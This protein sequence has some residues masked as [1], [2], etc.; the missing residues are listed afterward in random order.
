[1]PKFFLRQST[2]YAF[3]WLLEPPRSTNAVHYLTV[4]EITAEDAAQ[5]LIA[6]EYASA[7]GLLVVFPWF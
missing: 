7:F 4:P 6:S 5:H 2:S 3:L 1:M